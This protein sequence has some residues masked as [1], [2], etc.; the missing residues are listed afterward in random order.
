MPIA[1]FQGA[2]NPVIRTATSPNRRR[3]L[4]RHDA[5]RKRPVPR[6]RDHPSPTL[7]MRG[8]P[9]HSKVDKSEIPLIINGGILAEKGKLTDF[10]LWMT[11]FHTH[12][13]VPRAITTHTWTYS[14]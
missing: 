13:G 7:S 10:V 4:L 11:S 14:Y 3:L 2:Y 9:L 8:M 5:K 1:R 12:T 6:L